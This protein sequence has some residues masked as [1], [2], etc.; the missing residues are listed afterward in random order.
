MESS[1]DV[2]ETSAG[3]QTVPV[4]FAA[5]LI[6][7]TENAE[8][9]KRLLSLDAMRGFA[10]TGMIV[11][12]TVAFSNI[13]YGY[14]PAS[15]I[16]S[17]SLWAGFTF[18]DF[19]F[20][21]F[22]FTAGLSIAISLH[23]ASLEWAM[24]GR[25]CARAL[26]LLALGVLLANV[27]LFEQPGAW[28][29]LGVLQRIGICYFATALLFLSCGPRARLILALSLLALYWPVALLPVPNQTTNLLIPGANFVSYLD[30]TALGA[31]ALITGAHGYDP[32][33]LLSTL[34]AFAQCLLGA[35][36]G[37]WLLKHRA[38]SDA[39][40]KLAAAGAASLLIGICWSP[41]FPLIKNIWSSSYVLV[42]SG[43]A[44]LVFCFFYWA[45]DEKS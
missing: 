40:P 32:E 12:N 29:C 14:P 16:L 31:H 34:P 45:L 25:I 11:V 9:R 26:A 1:M 8:S 18:A 33:G 42:S 7:A 6:P 35:A 3:F 10:V 37:E 13:S 28:R 2:V 36:A 27:T 38:R 21:A 4:S 19:V 39:L 15:Q 20:P 22:V 17:H 5:P 41:F 23:H 30:R 43:L 44:T 24:L